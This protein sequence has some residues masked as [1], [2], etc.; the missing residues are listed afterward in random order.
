[1]KLYYFLIFFLIFL[2]LL[3]K[4]L[5]FNANVVGGLNVTIISLASL[6]FTIN[7]LDFGTGSVNFGSDNATIDTLGNVIDG[8]WTPSYEGF[9]IENMGNTN[10]GVFLKS[11]RSASE[12]LGGTNPGYYYMI[13]NQ[14]A[15]SCSEEMMPFN[16]WITVNNS[17]YG[18][19]VCSNMS[20]SD[21]KDSLRLDIRLIIP[22][23][24]LSGLRT[25]TFT[26]TG[27][28]L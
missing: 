3:F 6:N 20:Y 7:Y 25:D 8:N 5:S 27:I 9:V 12:F 21:T 15:E 19:K 11:A 22:S 1:M 16:S 24:A 26:A 14:E 13:T 4:P 18:D 28:S 10:L 2:F 23:D 17:G